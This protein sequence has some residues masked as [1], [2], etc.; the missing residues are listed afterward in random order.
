ME[1][2]ALQGI[3]FVLSLIPILNLLVGF[4]S[5][6]AAFGIAPEG[7]AVNL[8]SQLRYLSGVYVAISIVIW[9]S[10]PRIESRVVPL[11]L[12]ALGIVLGGLG[13][14]LSVA[15]Y[16]W[17]PDPAMVG[18]LFL[19]VLGVPLLVLWHASFARRHGPGAAVRAEP[20][21]AA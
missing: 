10:V 14:V 1:R 15:T 18:G 11:R 8:D 5:G 21:R 17:P 9:W 19:E 13:R 7:H 16:G 6:V 3:L 20:A 4:L 2:R 12:V